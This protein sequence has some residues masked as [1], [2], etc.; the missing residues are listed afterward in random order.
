MP[1]RIPG[2]VNYGPGRPS[3]TSRPRGFLAGLAMSNDAGDTDHDIAIS[4]GECS[5]STNA[6]TITIDTIIT[7]R[8]DDDGGGTWV[9]GNDQ[10]GLPSGCAAGIV[11]IDTWYHV[12]VISQ[13]DGTSD[14]GFDTD[15]TA[16]NLRAD[17]PA[18]VYYRRIGS[19]L[20][21]NPA[22]IRGFHQF[23]DYLYWDTP[24]DDLD[25]NAAADDV[26]TLVAMSGILRNADGLP[27]LQL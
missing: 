17:A 2:H 27:F 25:T 16:A 14:A 10:D 3:W 9:V 22:N 21:G 24:E 15:L 11:Q 4:V 19:V 20:T 13:V 26:K 7:K 18:Y 8:I 6:V 23:G 1:L 12:F 5:D